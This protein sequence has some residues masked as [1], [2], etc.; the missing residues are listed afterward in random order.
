MFLLVGGGLGFGSAVVLFRGV[1]IPCDAFWPE[2][3]QHQQTKFNPTHLEQSGLLSSELAIPFEDNHR[4]EW[5]PF[6][7]A[8]T[9]CYVPS[10]S[11][12]VSLDVDNA[13]VPTG[14]A[15]PKAVALS[16]Q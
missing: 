10:P 4:M 5:M 7:S 14:G 9:S 12:A 8:Q 15:W 11:P 3:S 16:R 13:V 1:S 6:E 2:K